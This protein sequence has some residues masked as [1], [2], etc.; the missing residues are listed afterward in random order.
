MYI[1]NVNELT[2]KLNF[3]FFRPRPE[4]LMGSSSIEENDGEGAGISALNGRLSA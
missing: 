4:G 2:G 3:E 1:G